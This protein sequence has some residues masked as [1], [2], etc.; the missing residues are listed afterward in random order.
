MSDFA[1][2]S[3]NDLI[4]NPSAR[5]PC[6][7]VLDTSGSMY[8]NPI[9][10]LNLGVQHFLQ[11]LYDD[12]VAAC[13]VEVAV[14]TAG[15]TVQTQLPFTTAMSIEG[16]DAITAYGT[17]PLG[18]A[19][20]QALDMLEQRKAEYRKNGVPYYQPWLVVISDGTPTDSWQA[21]A[22]RANEL[23]VQRKLVSLMVG[24]EGADMETLGQFSNRPA[25]KL[26]GLKFNEFFQWLSASMSRV[27]NSAST[28]SAVNLPP[29][30]A[31]AS[32]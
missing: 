5:C 2:I 7:L 4:E 30:D 17:T 28:T 29:M 19:V 24:V 27:S 26:Q 14:V 3:A 15:D 20:N 12:E 13:S 9:E 1:L 11:A 18:G 16:F 32:I 8:G 10:Q 21:A 6:V 31:W 25:L 22:S 23:A